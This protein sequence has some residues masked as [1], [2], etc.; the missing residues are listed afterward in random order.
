MA[1]WLPTGK[2][3]L[4]PQ[5]V[6][7]VLETD[8][9]VKGTSIYFHAGTDRLL[10][11]GHP[12]FPI[13]DVADR[14]KILVPHV[15]GSQFRVF[16]MKLPDPNRFALIEKGIYN[17]EHQRLVWKLRGLEVGRGGPLGIGT[18]GH[19][20]YNKLN[21]TENPNKYIKQSDDNRQDVSLDPKQTQLFIVGC[22]PPIGEH[23]DVAKPCAGAQFNKG[24]CPPIQLVNS[25]IQDGDMCDIGF[26]AVNNAKFQE[27]KSSATLDTIATTTKWPDFLKMGKDI[28][29]DSLFF[30]GRREQVYARHYFCRAGTM[31]DAIPEPFEPTSDYFI[32]AQD[33]QDQ[34]TIASHVYFGTPSGSLVS[35]E[36]QV[37]NRPY[38]L[39]RAQGT[40]NGICWGN[41]L[42]V[43]VV[44]NT[45]N[46]NFT[47][48]VK[49]EGAD[50]DY[51]YKASDFNQFLRHVEE[52]EMEFIFQLCIVPLDAD[53]LAHLNVM[54]PSILE[55]WQLSFVPPPPSG[56]ED[57][58]RFITSTATRCPDQQP[59]EKVDPYAEFTFWTVDL[60][61]RFSSELSQFSLGRRF[62]YQTGL[63]T[64]GKR[65]RPIS[66]STTKR[67]SKKRRIK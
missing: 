1:A 66:T 51:K 24:D 3:Y 28:Y 48:S 5:P 7:R 49:K 33:G 10:T 15:S 32:G 22:A 16:R 43:T 47:L 57:A 67:A 54:N 62:I 21:D 26:G 8:E 60:T 52:F 17:P 45:H 59:V 58:Y 18:T 29:G 12:Y 14:N 42:F 38:W 31:G 4:P 19:P 23:W 25:V 61:D 65:L 53:V 6:A 34:K 20:L 46:T 11:V 50:N 9:Y 55:E 56:I 39:Q 44:D 41:N 36:S 13:R 37:F 2:L 30:Y 63:I 40:N 35:S 27:D 64:N